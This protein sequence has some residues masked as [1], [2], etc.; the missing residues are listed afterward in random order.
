MT[1]AKSG[2]T[3]QLA[4]RGRRGRLG[5][6]TAAVVALAL[7]ASACSSSG[8]ESAKPS[9]T[10][11]IGYPA[12]LISLNPAKDSYGVFPHALAE[13]TIIRAKTDGTYGPNLAKSWR[14]VGTGNKTFEFTLRPGLKFSDGTALDAAAAAAWMNYFRKSGGP[15]AAQVAIKAITATSADT[16]RIS[17]GSSNPDLPYYLSGPFNL[18]YLVSPKAISDPKS[19]DKQTVGAGP[20]VL[21]ASKTVENNSYTFVPNKY[22]YDKSAVKYKKVVIKIQETSASTLAALQTGEI[23]V[24]LGDYSTVKAASNADLKVYPVPG[25]TV[26][27]SFFDR[28][29]KIAKALGDVRVRQALNYALNRKEIAKAIIGDEGKATSEYATTDGYDPSLKD[30]YKYDRAKAKALLA[31]AGYPSGFTFTALVENTPGVLSATAAQAMAEQYKAIGVTMKIKTTTSAQY[32]TDLFSGKYPAQIVDT[33]FLPQFVNYGT[34]LAPTA[35]VNPMKVTVPEIDKVAAQGA[36]SDSPEPFWKEISRMY[37]EDAVYAPV[38]I[39]DTF[40]FASKSVG[41]IDPT[42]KELLDPTVWFPK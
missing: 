39:A 18:G 10:L 36:A 20:Y 28:D 34:Y 35:V 4:R 7:G 29:G 13:A 33:P 19:L 12:G 40:I 9:S 26:G 17:L 31:S 1:N 6:A 27:L 2:D 42:R 15:F 24:G 22:Y 30:Y 16:V 32:V 37:T 25:N 14:Y 41:G 8:G 21:D 11:T 5:A 23:Q 3:T 38:A